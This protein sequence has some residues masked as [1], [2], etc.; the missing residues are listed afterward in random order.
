MNWPTILATTYIAA[1]LLVRVVMLVL[2]PRNRSTGAA[3]AWLMLIMFLPWVG[4]AAYVLIGSPKLPKRRREHQREMNAMLTKIVARNEADPKLAPVFT[5]DLNERHQPIAALAQRL[6]GMPP[7]GESEA[8]LLPEY[9]SA[10]GHI[11]A[12]INRAQ[13]EVHALFY[14]FADDSI[15]RSFAHALCRAAARGVK[16]RVLVDWLGS[17]S[18]GLRH[19]VRMLREGG[20]EVHPALP[21]SLRDYSRIDLR[22]H[23]KIVVIDGTVGY[24]GSQ[25]I[26]CADFKPG[27]EY[28]ELMARVTGPIVAQLQATFLT[29]WFSETHTSLLEAEAPPLGIERIATGS[30]VAQVLP[31]GPAYDVDHVP[32]LF[33]A[34][35]HAAR[36]RAVLVTPYFIPDDA[37]LRAIEAAAYRGVDVHI[38]V[39]ETAD[40]FVVSRAQRSYYDEL[41]GA[42]V[43]VHL[44]QPPFLL[45]A[46]HLSIDDDM[47]VIG[48]S[49]VD[50]RSFRLD[51][52]ILLIFY[53]QRVTTSLRAI[54]EQYFAASYTLDPDQWRRRPLAQ[55]LVENTLRLVSP[56]L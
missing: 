1:E 11:I 40:Q 55:Q 38:V 22:N 23:R 10:I 31:S 3:A 44:Y 20:V 39:S 30:L 5:V 43:T 16:V 47:A 24:T 19:V 34:L 9:E 25:N 32:L 33:S 15:G 26:V 28:K 29:D 13:Q 18:L 54:E 14:I 48:S 53:G 6:G 8:M 35:L 36:E 41:L 37:L 49:N 7:V 51:L 27:I 2:V 46:K 56:L 45:H 21:F 42:G 17:R 4:L 12:D 50:I 52:E